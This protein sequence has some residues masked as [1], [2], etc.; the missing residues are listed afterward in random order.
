MADTSTPSKSKVDT[1][2][3]PVTTPHSIQPQSSLSEHDK[4]ELEKLKAMY[5]NK[6]LSE[7]FALMHLSSNRDIQSV[8]EDLSAVKEKVRTL[9][10]FAENVNEEIKSIN[11]ESLVNLRDALTE[12]EMERVKLEQWGRK[13]NVVIGGVEGYLA[14]KPR[15]TEEKVRQFMCNT[16][17][18]D[19]NIVGRMIFQA[20]HRLPGGDESKRPII[21]RFVSLIDRDDVMDAARRLRRGCGYSVIPDLNPEASR[22]R[23]QLLKSLR[24]MSS[25]ERKQ[26]KLVYMK[27]YPYV[28]IKKITKKT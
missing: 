11:E 28:D 21:L 23:S 2:H 15:V 16:L 24:E 5:E 3:T 25:E 13:W 1:P 7:C 12:E 17:N 26:N 4:A 20:V 6:S 14:E 27:D 10:S 18:M 22:R 8:R 19:P 9:E